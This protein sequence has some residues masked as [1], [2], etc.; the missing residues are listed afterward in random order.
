[1]K[2][3][4]PPHPKSRAGIIAEKFIPDQVFIYVAAGTLKC[5]DATESYAFSKGECFIARK[6]RLAKY[7]IER[8]AEGFEPIAFCFDEAFL[9]AYVAKHPQPLK[10]FAPKD[11]FIK[12]VE[13]EL[14]ASFIQSLKPYY[15]GPYEI[16]KD[17]EAVKY[18]E[19]LIILLKSQPHLA[20]LL[21]DFG[22][23]A[24][25]DLEEFM[26]KNFTFNVSLGRFAFLT[27]RSISA[28]KRDFY[29]TF[30]DT[31][32]RWLV[33]RRL[34]EAWFLI[35]EKA[36]RPSDIYLDLGFESLS[37]FSAAFKKRFALTPTDLTE[38][39]KRLSL[40]YEG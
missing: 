29:A 34:E 9:K 3:A 27:G 22:I 18:E 2:P 5:F 1:M 23:P 8:S 13:T 7:K 17:F 11:T 25:I 33:Q 15:I 14:L 36:Q 4:T 28:F 38:R 39:K 16:D 19:L 10:S 32:S 31:P 40:R 37:H 30:N 35:D 6:N 12:V 26:Q 21:F 20:G 24:K